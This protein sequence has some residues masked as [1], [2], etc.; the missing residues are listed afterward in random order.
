MATVLDREAGRGLGRFAY[1][2]AATAGYARIAGNEHYF[3]DVVPGMLVGH[4]VGRL[5]TRHRHA[6]VAS[7]AAPLPE[8]PAHGRPEKDSMRSAAAIL[9]AVCVTLCTV[10]A[11]AAGAQPASVSP[12]QYVWVLEPMNCDPGLRPQPGGPYAALVFCENALGA[13][14]AVVRLAP[15]ERT[16]EGAWNTKQ[17]IWQEEPWAS[18]ITSFAWAPDGQRLFVTTADGAGAGGLYELELATRRARQVAPKDSA[19]TAAKPGPGYVIERLDRDRQVLHYRAI[20]WNLP[21]GV[22]AEDSLLLAPPAAAPAKAPKAKSA[23]KH[24]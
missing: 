21:S 7:P 8:P 20:P 4:L 1:P 22:S 12:G 5:V 15:L 10:L 11:G 24:K 19:V 16:G 18:D 13:Y 17:L 2:A 14:L 23:S 6:A 3:S 9:P